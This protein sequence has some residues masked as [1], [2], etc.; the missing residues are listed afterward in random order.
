MEESQNN[1]VGRPLMFQS[2]EELDQKINEYFESRA[3]HVV[4]R[5]IKRTKADGGS[6]W[7]EDRL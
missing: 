6:Y 7:A 2:V 5:L 3:P 4:K 1:K